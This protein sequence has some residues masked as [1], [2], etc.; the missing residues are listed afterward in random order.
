[1][2]SVLNMSEALTHLNKFFSEMV[3]PGRFKFVLDAEKQEVNKPDHS[4]GDKK[5]RIM[6]IDIG[7]PNK[8]TYLG[9]PHMPM[10]AWVDY[11]DAGTFDSY[12][13]AVRDLK[14]LNDITMNKLDL[15]IIDN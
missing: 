2:E 6:R 14:R 13:S 15:R 3:G 9:K 12:E 1:M 8:I 7:P 4:V 5:F 10:G 11:L